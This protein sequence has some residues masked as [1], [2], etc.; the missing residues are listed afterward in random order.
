MELT[1]QEQ[2]EQN[3]RDAKYGEASKLIRKSLKENLEDVNMLLQLLGVYTLA[4]RDDDVKEF[5]KDFLLKYPDSANAQA[6]HAYAIALDNSEKAEKEALRAFI[7]DNKNVLTH[8]VLGYVCCDLGKYDEGINELKQVTDKFP[9][10][11][12][13]L[14]ILGAGYFNKGEIKKAVDI[15]K[16]IIK[17]AP[18]NIFGYSDL[19]NCYANKE[20]FVKGVEVWETGIKN[21]PQEPNFYLYLGNYYWDVIEDYDKT[22]EQ[23]EKALKI[24]PKSSW[25][26]QYLGWAFKNEIKDF[27]RAEF[28][29]N[30]AVELD[31]KDLNKYNDLAEIYRDLKDFGSGVKV[32]EMAIENNPEM[33]ECYIYLG[34]YYW[35][36]MQDYKNAH[37]AYL[38]AVEISPNLA[39]GYR[40]LGWSYREKPNRNYQKALECSLKAVELSPQDPYNH[41][42]LAYNYYTLRQK[43]D[44]I[45]E[46]KKAMSLGDEHY[47]TYWLYADICFKHYQRQ[48][49]NKS[50]DEA[51]NACIQLLRFSIQE[52]K[53]IRFAEKCLSELGLTQKQI[54]NLIPKI[55]PTSPHLI[56]QD[57]RAI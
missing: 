57:R 36:N 6:I 32:W 10:N 50:K 31:P 47:D 26:Y 46:L 48:K 34:D 42:A 28:Y 27:A 19:A 5:A 29:F 38:K 15:Y 43:E 39:W 51:M 44:A 1:L 54:K 33:A 45:N 13:V 20:D 55:I 16:K 4:E 12:F 25:V 24:S 53:S 18:H 49:D 14:R 11:V 37:K 23:Y 40:N 41:R 7:T 21:N 9:Q 35:H 2:I 22:Q 3:I 30:K 56:K 17:F 8:F 52:R